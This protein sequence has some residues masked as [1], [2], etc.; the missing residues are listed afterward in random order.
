MM[1]AN[2]CSIAKIHVGGKVYDRIK[3]GAPGTLTREGRKLPDATTAMNF[4]VIFTT[5]NAMPGLRSLADHLRMRGR[6][7]RRVTGLTSSKEIL[8]SDEQG[9]FCSYEKDSLCMY[10]PV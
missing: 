10:R 5:R 3:V 1:K 8:F 6:F 4:S 7:H 9:F 2:G